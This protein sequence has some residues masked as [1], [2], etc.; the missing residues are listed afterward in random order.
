MKDDTERSFSC[1]SLAE[2]VKKLARYEIPTSG[3]LVY[4]REAHR[5]DSSTVKLH[6]R[7]QKGL[8]FIS[9]ED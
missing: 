3:G 4:S 8:S 9:L 1:V 5:E 6:F 2:G 7:R